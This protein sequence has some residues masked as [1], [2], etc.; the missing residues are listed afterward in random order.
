MMA[1]GIIIE[2]IMILAQKK[3]LLHQECIANTQGLKQFKTTNFT[4]GGVPF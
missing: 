3:Q 4:H 2:K 1:L